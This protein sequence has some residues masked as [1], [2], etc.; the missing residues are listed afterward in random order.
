VSGIVI[1]ADSG[2]P[3]ANATVMARFAGGNVTTLT[4]G[5]GSYAVAF[6]ATQPYTTDPLYTA[7]PATILGL[8]IVRDGEY[9][10]DIR[11]GR[12]TTVQL[13]PWGTA[14]VVQNVRLR[15]VRTIAAG[16]SMPVSIEPDSSLVWDGDWEPWQFL[17]YDTVWEHFVVAIDRDGILSIDVRP[18]P[19]GGP[20][21]TLSCPYVGCPAG[22]VQGAVSISLQS[23]W[24][25]FYFS[26]A[27]PRGIAP[28]RY[29]ILTSFQ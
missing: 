8:L 18:E 2:S 16:Q 10:G 6:E 5:D 26:I 7:P 29:E 20:V 15:R 19:G 27:I 12:W 25:P 13:L 9:W 1:D 11:R 22:K 21:P 3:I 23:R 28:Q 4:N 24:S 17:S 14:D